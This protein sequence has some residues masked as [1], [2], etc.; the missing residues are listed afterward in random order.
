MRT[1]MR[2]IILFAAIL[3]ACRVLWGCSG[4]G[5]PTVPPSDGTR[6]TGLLDLPTDVSGST[7]FAGTETAS[8]DGT[9]FNIRLQPNCTQVVSV[10][11]GGNLL[12]AAVVLNTGL[13]QN[14]AIT[15]RSTAEALLLLTPFVAQGTKDRNAD[16][17]AIIHDLPETQRLAVAISS[18][19]T[20]LGE[21][22]DFGNPDSAFNNALSTALEALF[23]NDAYREASLWNIKPGAVSSGLQIKENEA[24]GDNDF[25]FIATNYARRYVD[26]YESGSRI[27]GLESAGLE[28]NYL[29]V[30]QEFSL[31]PLFQRSRT[32]TAYGPGIYSVAPFPSEDFTKS[33]PPIMKSLVFDA[34]IPCINIIFGR[35]GLGHTDTVEGVVEVILN[36]QFFMDKVSSFIEDRDYFTVGVSVLFKAADFLAM[37]VI[38]NGANSILAEYLGAYVAPNIAGNA[39]LPLKLLGTGLKM[40]NPNLSVKAY[41]ECLT[42]KK[43]NLSLKQ[44]NIQFNPVDVSPLLLNFD[45]FDISVDGHYAYVAGDEDGLLIFDISSPVNPVWVNRVVVPDYAYSVAV[46]SGCAYVT[47]YKKLTIID[48]DPP[49]FESIIATVDLGSEGYAA[50]LAV[51]GGYAY[52]S[53]S[54]AGLEIVNIDPPESAYIVNMVDTPGYAD[55]VAVS[56]EYAYVADEEAGLQIIDIDPPE[57]ASIVKTVDTPGYALSVAV[58]GGYAYVADFFN[59]LQIIDISTIDS[60]YIVSNVG[61]QGYDDCLDVAGGYAYVSDGIGGIQ[62]VDV[63]P[64]ESAYIVKTIGIS[65]SAWA[66]TISSGYAYVAAGYYGFSII[67][68]NPPESA[69]I[70]STMNALGE[71]EDVAIAGGYAYVADYDLGLQIVDIDQPDSA[72]IVATV[73]TPFY[74]SDVTVSGGYAYVADSYA[75][76]QIIDIDPPE[77]ASIVNTVETPGNADGVAVSGGYAYVADWDVGLQIVDIDPPG[78]ASI[79]KTI[80]ADWAFDVAVSGDYAYVVGGEEGMLV[81]NIQPPESAY[82]VTTVDTSG[83][84]RAVTVLDGY[85]YIAAGYS[86]LKIVDLEPLETASVVA[87]VSMPGFVYDV[88]VSGNYAYVADGDGGIQIVDLQPPGLAYIADSFD[89]PGS[90]EGVAV[91]GE[92]AY[93]ADWWGGLRIIKLW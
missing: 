6:M 25:D 59:G 22:A 48:I 68:V 1:I 58:S 84:G 80:P 12:G 21:V 65:G 52:V 10:I 15:P 14:I 50:S 32:I 36:D 71:V 86:G 78:S 77:L 37:D 83:G 76:L 38:T 67:N 4:G 9:N 18:D 74:V 57:S 64:P 44:E 81:V 89:T 7:V 35:S 13:V 41:E 39:L 49:G 46:S 34:V 11:K 82:I 5:A 56:G 17:M 33:L 24:T 43:F 16:M 8:L 27:A 88:A 29:P 73:A 61:T 26:L 70:A 79:I 85:A 40:A 93:V 20:N 31:S 51:A 47:G 92:Y 23:K 2:N 72:Y 55:K 60:A 19:L 91:S 45:A 90:A 63:E 53:M 66:I 87:D 75:G 69:Y 54:D 3:V 42:V 62:L 30:E 28:S